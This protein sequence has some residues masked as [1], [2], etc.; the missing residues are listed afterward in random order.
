MVFIVFCYLVSATLASLPPGIMLLNRSTAPRDSATEIEKTS[1]K[2]A[3]ERER[4]NRSVVKTYIVRK[5]TLILPWQCNFTNKL[6]TNNTAT[7]IHDDQGHVHYLSDA[8][9]NNIYS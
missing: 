7:N 3:L 2:G 6:T 9:T 1:Q 5:N 4:P 8:R